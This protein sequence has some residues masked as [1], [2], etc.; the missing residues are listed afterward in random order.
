MF[1]QDIHLVPVGRTHVAEL[2]SAPQQEVCAL[3]VNCVKL[4]HKLD[5]V[6][7]KINNSDIRKD[8]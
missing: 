3:A 4:A 8:L 7:G 5:A 2:G 6:D 1:G